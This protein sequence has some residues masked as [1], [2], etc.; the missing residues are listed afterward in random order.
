M[1][2]SLQLFPF[3]VIY[4]PE[5]LILMLSSHYNGFKKIVCLVSHHYT[6]DLLSNVVERYICLCR[7]HYLS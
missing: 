3:F 2:I 4:Y 7:Q 5:G 6:D 1:R